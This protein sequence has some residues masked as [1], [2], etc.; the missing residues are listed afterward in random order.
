LARSAPKAATNSKQPRRENLR[1]ETLRAVIKSKEKE[2]KEAVHGAH[3]PGGDDVPHGDDINH[4][5]CPRALIAPTSTALGKTRETRR[6]GEDEKAAN[7]D[8][9]SAESSSLGRCDVKY[10]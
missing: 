9:G 3:A 10:A 1:W 7:S 5:L 2:R 8:R 4:S 6:L